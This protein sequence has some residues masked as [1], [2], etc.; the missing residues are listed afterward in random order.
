MCEC[1]YE[2]EGQARA[3]DTGRREDGGREMPMQTETG[4][5]ISFGR[6]AARGRDTGEERRRSRDWDR[7]RTEM[8]MSVCGCVRAHE[9]VY[10]YCVRAVEGYRSDPVTNAVGVRVS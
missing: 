2:K 10:G 7:N 6:V 1:V 9:C 5:E 4:M 8:R 3:P